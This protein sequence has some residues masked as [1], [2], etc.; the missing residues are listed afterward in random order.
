MKCLHKMQSMG[1]DGGMIINRGLQH[2]Q[3]W[4]DS[5]IYVWCNARS[6]AGEVLGTSRQTKKAFLQPFIG[7]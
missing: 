3:S 7:P 6:P 2:L 1:H 5:L 4:S